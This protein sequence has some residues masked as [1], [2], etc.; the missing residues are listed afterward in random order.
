[1]AKERTFE[2]LEKA[3]LSKGESKC[4]VGKVSLPSMNGEE[5]KV[6]VDGREE[7]SAVSGIGSSLPDAKKH[8]FVN[9]PP[10]KK[11]PGRPKGTYG[12]R[13]GGYIDPE[14]GRRVYA[15]R[16]TMKVKCD[17]SPG[18]VFWYYNDNPRSKFHGQWRC[19]CKTMTP[20]GVNANFVPNRVCQRVDA[21]KD[22]GLSAEIQEQIEAHKR[23]LKRKGR[24]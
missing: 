17:L 6:C 20:R 8:L 12:R 22:K 7:K 19:K 15:D 23:R 5:M 3:S 4:R 2:G 16:P 11:G 18:G 10:R 14:T 24:K 13:R 21:P 1:M 9:R